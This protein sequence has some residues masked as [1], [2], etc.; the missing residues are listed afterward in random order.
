LPAG[1]RPVR[2]A[3]GGA[4][5]KAFEIAYEGTPTWDIGRPQ[6]AVTRLEEAGLIDGRV[7]DAG[8]GTGENAL[9]LAARGHAV[10]GVDFAPSAIAKATR[11]AGDRRLSGRVSFVERDALT[12]GDIGRSFDTIL[13]VGLFHT[14][15][16][17]DRA[18]Y[19]AALRAVVA[20]GGRCLVL[21]WSDRNPFGYGPERVGRADLR[22]AFR[23][24]WRV[25]SITDEV[26]ET[27]LPPGHV[28]AWLARLEPR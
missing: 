9:Y 25:A 3:T 5:T 11:R 10:L 17:A 26:L 20:P 14:L 15:Q 12:L 27:L 13:D 16:P 2:H 24:G 19:A 4:A 8:C 6:A 1:R 22:R 28:H 18:A 23:G 7:L 21:A